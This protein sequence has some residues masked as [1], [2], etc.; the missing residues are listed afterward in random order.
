M[1]KKYAVIGLLQN[2]KECKLLRFLRIS[3]ILGTHIVENYM[4]V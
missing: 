2:F 4:Y 3:R 1:K